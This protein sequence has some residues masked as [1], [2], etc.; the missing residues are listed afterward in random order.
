M[1][2]KRGELPKARRLLPRVPVRPRNEQSTPTRLA[3]LART[4]RLKKGR[5]GY[6]FSGRGAAGR[7]GLMGGVRGIIR[8]V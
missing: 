2:V 5:G 8:T 3:G 4:A 1:G 7:S 6:P